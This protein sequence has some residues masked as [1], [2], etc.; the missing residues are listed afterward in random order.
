MAGKTTVSERNRSFQL[1]CIVSDSERV[2]LVVM[3]VLYCISELFDCNNFSIFFLS[4]FFYFFS[5][6][7][8]SGKNVRFSN[9]IQPSPTDFPI[10]DRDRTVPIPIPILIFPSMVMVSSKVVEL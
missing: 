4:I 1:A 9:P 7:Q 8:A 5:I 10:R 3:L 6:K 2:F